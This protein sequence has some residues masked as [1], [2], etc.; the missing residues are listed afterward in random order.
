MHQP[1]LFSIEL[2][3]NFNS[4][5]RNTKMH[6]HSIKCKCCVYINGCAQNLPILK[7]LRHYLKSNDL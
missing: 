2:Q 3:F 7:L 6:I 4:L 1:G 5:E